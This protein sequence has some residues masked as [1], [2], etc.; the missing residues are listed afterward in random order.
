MAGKFPG[1]SESNVGD[2]D[3]APDEEVGETGQGE[4]PSEKS[5]TTGLRLV[6]E[7][8]KTN[9]QLKDDCGDGSA[10]LV[11]VRKEFGCHSLPCKRLD[12]ASRAIRC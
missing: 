5:A 8:Q 4:K 11:D 12:R 10:T 9:D 7:S 1:T 2:T 6:G 3:T